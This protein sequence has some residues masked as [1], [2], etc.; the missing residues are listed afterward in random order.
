MSGKK[1]Y[2]VIGDNDSFPEA[3]FKFIGICVVIGLLAVLKAFPVMWL[4]NDL[5]PVI[6]QNHQI[7]IWHSIELCVL[8]SCLFAGSSSSS[9]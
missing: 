2:D 4:F 5:I 1:W 8:V 7:D 3:L 9:K 6:I